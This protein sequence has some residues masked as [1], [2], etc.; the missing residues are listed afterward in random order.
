[1][2]MSI[3]A[4]LPLRALNGGKQRLSSVLSTAER[5]AL[6]EHLFRHTLAAITSSGVIDGV[7]VV[8]PDPAVLDWVASLGVLPV[9]QGERGLNQGLEQARCALLVEKWIDALLVVLPDLP[10]VTP[11][12][13]AALAKRS[14]P[15]SVVLAPDRHGQGTNALLVRPANA[16]PWAFGEGSFDRHR[17]AAR[18]ERLALHVFHAQGT[19]FDVD[20]PDDWEMMRHTLAAADVE[21]ESILVASVGGSGI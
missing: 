6:V 8:S 5:Q 18:A 21:Q 14:A 11:A 20:M 16:L 7:C 10:L 1:M 2:N 15:H 9:L 3:W 12:D 17:A 13:I 4:I 19:A